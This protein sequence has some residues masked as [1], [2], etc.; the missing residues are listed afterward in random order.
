MPLVLS[1]RRAVRICWT[2]WGVCWRAR[3]QPI[4]AAVRQQRRL[5]A[6]RI[7]APCAPPSMPHM[8]RKKNSEKLFD[9]SRAKITGYYSKPQWE[10][11]NSDFWGYRIFW[12]VAALPFSAHTPLVEGADPSGAEDAN[13]RPPKSNFCFRMAERHAAAGGDRHLLVIAL[14]NRDDGAE[15]CVDK[16][17]V[18]HFAAAA[19]RQKARHLT[20]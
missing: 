3:R 17:L 9:L 2:N 1:S 12:G 6:Q 11:K 20:H 8:S 18:K 4:A 10:A 7:R 14:N 13:S 19:V 16:V 15:N 5:W